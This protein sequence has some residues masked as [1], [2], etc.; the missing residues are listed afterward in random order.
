[1]QALSPRRRRH[2]VAGEGAVKRSGGQ[3][4]TGI[5]RSALEQAIEQHEIGR[6][7]RGDRG[8]IIMVQ[9]GLGEVVRE[10]IGRPGDHRGAARQLNEHREHER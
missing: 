1:M 5:L 2:E 7:G 3:Q 10:R 8:R 4:Q 9:N 6:H